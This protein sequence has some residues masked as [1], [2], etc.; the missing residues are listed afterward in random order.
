MTSS[1][2]VTRYANALADVVM[3]GPDVGTRVVQ[4]GDAAAQLQAFAQL[5]AESNDLR[6][7]LTSP[8]VSLARKRA[9]ISKIVEMQGAARVVRN[10]LLVLSDHRRLDALTEVA[11]TFASVVDERLGFARAEIQSA[12]ELRP[13]QQ[14]D[15][16]VKISQLTGK[17]VR[18]AWKVNPQL[19]GGVVV[20]VGSKVYDGSVRGQLAAIGRKLAAI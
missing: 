7:A 6:N 16:V 20:N 18:P 15:L 17:K 10:F 14:D 1:A 4:P 9:V 8:S 12:Q 5:V 19:L 13:Q 11:S 3:G 2:V